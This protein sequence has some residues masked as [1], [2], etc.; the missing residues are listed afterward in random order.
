MAQANL[1]MYAR[2]TLAAAHSRLAREWLEYQPLLCSTRLEPGELL[3]LATRTA[4]PGFGTACVRAD[5]CP[6]RRAAVGR[7]P[8]PGAGSGMSNGLRLISE[9]SIS[10][11]APGE[12]TSE[13]K[14]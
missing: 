4:T 12:P 3:P 13:L 11:R 7:P 14:W 8:Y 9:S 1:A 5:P 2:T 6:V 10:N